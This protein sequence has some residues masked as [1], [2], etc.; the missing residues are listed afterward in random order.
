MNSDTLK[1]FR[2]ILNCMLPHDWTLQAPESRS[3][4]S[5]GSRSEVEM[6]KPGSLSADSLSTVLD[7]LAALADCLIGLLESCVLLARRD[8]APVRPYSL[9]RYTYCA[10]PS[11][12]AQSG[13]SWTTVDH[14]EFRPR[15]CWMSEHVGS[16][17]QTYYCFE[18]E[19]QQREPFKSLAVKVRTPDSPLGA[20]A[21]DSILRVVAHNKGLWVTSDLSAINM[22]CTWVTAR[23]FFHSAHLGPTVILGKIHA[24]G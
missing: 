19:A 23:H 10:F 12:T 18:I 8:Y 6:L 16:S 11:S 17:G 22:D 14:G 1:P 15:L 3:R 13:R 7:R 20:G 9:D 4:L 21:L 5:T 2:H 24:L